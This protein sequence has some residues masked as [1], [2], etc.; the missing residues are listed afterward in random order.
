MTHDAFWELIGLLDGV[1]DEDGADLLQARLASLSTEVVE[2]FATNL[3]DKVRALARLPI[4][5]VPV[6]DASDMGGQALSALGD[7]LENLLYAIVAAG[8]ANYSAAIEEPSSI[9]DGDWDGGEAELLVDAVATVLWS[10]ACLDW[11]E[12]FDPFLADLPADP[13]W[14]ETAR[15]SAWKS[16]PRR[17][18]YCSPLSNSSITRVPHPVCVGR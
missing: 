13:R 11:Y 14:Y 12:D 16:A 8:R 17:G 4:E 3:A 10:R 7:S 9:E 2:G 15:G 18:R 5:G 6:P 1:I